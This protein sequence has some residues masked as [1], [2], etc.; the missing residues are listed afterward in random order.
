MEG[1]LLFS[2]SNIKN[3]CF[4]VQNPSIRAQSMNVAAR[5]ELCVSWKVLRIAQEL[6][7]LLH[8]HLLIRL[9][10]VTGKQVRNTVA[11]KWIVKRFNRKLL[12]KKASSTNKEFPPPS[13][14]CMTDLYWCRIQIP[15]YMRYRAFF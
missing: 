14:I 3:S 6:T 11:E 12:S 13:R 10:R 8:Y 1:K 2:D 15:F 9:A 5:C 4:V 7:H